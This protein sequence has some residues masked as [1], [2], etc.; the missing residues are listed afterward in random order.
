MILKVLLNVTLEELEDKI[1]R[2][3][4][5][6]D[7]IELAAFCEF[8][9]VSMNGQKIPIYRLEYGKVTYF[10]YDIDE[11][12]NEK[13]L[14]GLTLGNLKLKKGVNFCIEYNFDNFYYFDLIIDNFIETDANNKNIDFKVLSG[15]G[16][17]II[18]NK[19]CGYLEALLIEKGKDYASYYLKSEKEY[20]QKNFDTNEVND[21]INNYKN[22]RKNM[23]LSKRYIFNVSLEGFN[24][25][26]KRKISVNSNITI[27]SFCKKVIVSM[28]GDLSHAFDVK[29]GAE[30]LGEYYS[31]I[32]LFYLNLSEKS[33]L[34]I[35]YDWGDNWQFNL[36]LSKIIDSTSEN[37]FEILSGKG[38]GIVDDCGGVWKLGKI[39]S[40]EV[41][42]WKGN[43]IN[44][45]N[46]EKCNE[47]VKKVS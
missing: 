43:D 34:K 2:Q 33:R 9:I 8:V 46:L 29:I 14:S 27:D 30:Y 22:N 10:P 36:T 45:F 25:E 5:V 44:E 12:K 28:N 39:F 15:K 4:L 20:L 37:K 26:I 16:Y 24:Q 19:M 1:N 11:T 42:G 17:G 35:F 38:Y 41:Y 23:L 13:T 7:N 40:G 3:I 47:D 21:R 31:N 32:E 6:D 18:D